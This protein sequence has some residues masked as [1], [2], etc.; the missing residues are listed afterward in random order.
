MRA[1]P[2][3]KTNLGLLL[4]LVLAFATG[5]GALAA[6]SWSGRWVVLAHGVAGVTVVL[7]SP[8][9]TRIVR[10]GLRRTRPSRWLSLG[11]AAL[12]VIALLTGLGSATGLVRSLAG[13]TALWVHVAAALLAAPLVIWHVVARPTRPRKTDLSRRSLLRA[14]TVGAAAAGFYVVTNSAVRLA[15]LPGADRRFTGSHET[16]SFDPEA[17]PNTIWLNDSSPAI[18]PDTWRLEVAD[19]AGERVL[20]LAELGIFDDRFRA[21][22]DCTGGWYAE[23][24]WEGVFVSTL[25]MNAGEARSLHVRSSTGYG[26]RFPVQDLDRLLLAT[27]VA[28]ASLSEGHGFPLRLVAPGRRGFWWVKWVDRIELQVTPWWWQPPFPVT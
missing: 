14:G 15:G 21:I 4:A 16:G 12:V 26:I 6:G 25:V 19:A 20:S 27:R 22:L 7:L 8:W 28:G 9:K 10:R 3:R 5:I 13:R 24:D 18:D 2:G 23:Q 11:L 1:P 17:M